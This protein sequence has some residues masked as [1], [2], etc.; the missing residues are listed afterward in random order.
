MK[1]KYRRRI[2]EF[3]RN[4]IVE[5]IFA[6]L[7]YLYDKTLETNSTLKIQF[8]QFF[9]FLIASIITGFVAFSYNG[10]FKYSEKISFYY[11]EKN[12][13]FVFITTPLTFIL[14]WWLVKRFAPNSTGSGI[15]Q[16]MVT[17]ELST[18]QKRHL[19]RHFL[20]L[21][22]IVIKVLSSCIKVMGGG[23]VGREGPTIQISSSI[24]NKVH[25][26][27]PKWWYPISQKNILIAG[28]ASGLAAAFNTPLGGIIFAIEELS[29]YHIKYYKSPLFI[30]VII[31][32]LTAQGFG[33]AYLYL[34]H[35]KASASG[36]TVYAG[37]FIVALFCGIFGTWMCIWLLK[38]L[39]FGKQLDT[40]FKQFSLVLALAMILATTFYFLGTDA[41][42]SGKHIM[43]HT[44]FTTD[45]SVEWYLPFVRMGGLIASFGSGGSG[46][47]FAPSLSTGASFGAWIADWLHLT[48]ENANLLVLVGM[49]SFLTAVT[50]APFTSAIIVFE[51]TDRHSV[52]FFLL[53]GAMIA[54][55]VA[56]LVS[57]KSLYDHIKE[58]YLQ[59]IEDSPEKYPMKDSVKN[60]I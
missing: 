30:A 32:G 45:K 58:N 60:P 36:F 50:R 11:Y 52:I 29:K 38:V 28:A 15:P 46:G 7:K 42:G 43:E 25:S 44:L 13:L 2:V 31:A 51:M 1:I 10:L 17:V 26:L 47:V 9:P 5:V 54:N 39:K 4:P 6:Y 40:N 23:I 55:M 57:E 53:V 35:P 41:M 8:F 3:R 18:P 49:T 48:G 37:I 16:V 21:K 56:S 20:N 22:V 19:I 34:E 24:F 14:S 12:S 59:E 27:L 33:G